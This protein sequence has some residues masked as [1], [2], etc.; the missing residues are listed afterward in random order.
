MEKH[1]ITFKI[2]SKETVESVLGKIYLSEF[3]IIGDYLTAQG[4]VWEDI[5][6]KTVKYIAGDKIPYRCGN[7]FHMLKGP[8]GMQG[9]QIVF[10]FKGEHVPKIEPKPNRK[11]G[12]R[13]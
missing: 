13:S 12:K 8:Y 7:K 2:R 3:K 11:Y 10:R 9:Y 5:N 6:L 1:Q 4:K